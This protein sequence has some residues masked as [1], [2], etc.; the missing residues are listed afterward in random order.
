MPSTVAVP[1]P[2][3]SAERNPRWR[4]M[5][6]MSD[7]TAPGGIAM[8]KPAMRP[9]RNELTARTLGLRGLRLVVLGSLIELGLRERDPDRVAVG[10]SLAELLRHHEHLAREQSARG[11]DAA[12]DDRR[13]GIADQL[14]ARPGVLAI[15]RPDG[16]AHLKW[17]R[18]VPCMYR[19]ATA[20]RGS[21]A[22][23]RRAGA[24]GSSPSARGRARSCRVRPMGDPG[25]LR[26]RRGCRSPRRP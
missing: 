18:A 5:R 17:H 16:G 2:A 1:Q 3:A 14:L 6:T 24:S 26:P 4:P 15:A 8:A 10:R 12:G 7:V 20:G 19:A 11:D 23:S 9:V 21:P 13:R 25:G 22:R